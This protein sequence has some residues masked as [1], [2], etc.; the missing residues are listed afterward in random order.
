MT[1]SLTV[2]HLIPQQELEARQAQAALQL[3]ATQLLEAQTAKALE[4]FKRE[5]AAALAK[6]AQ[7]GEAEAARTRQLAQQFEEAEQQ[8]RFPFVWLSVHASINP[9]HP[10]PLPKTTHSWPRPTRSCRRPERRAPRRSAGSRSSRRS[11]ASWLGSWRR[12]SGPPR[13]CGRRARGWSRPRGRRYGC[14]GV[15][16]D[17]FGFG[18]GVTG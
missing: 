5:S 13:R 14:V 17:G 10:P 11:G 6:H 15:I 2:T 4:S 12:R 3:N 16:G 9:T 18:F 1:P 8:V 7:A